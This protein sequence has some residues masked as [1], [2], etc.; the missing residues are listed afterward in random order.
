LAYDLSR[1]GI[2]QQLIRIEAM[3][4]LR[5]IRSMHSVTVNGAGTDACDIAVPDFVRVL[6]QLDPLELPLAI[7]VEQTQ[8]DF[9]GVRGKK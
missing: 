9:G 7:A 2:Q 4:L 6:G 3:T 8:L 1:V 5:F